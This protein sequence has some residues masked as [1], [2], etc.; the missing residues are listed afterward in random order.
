MEPPAS[1]PR[2]ILIIRPS[3]LGDVCRSV[4]VLAALRARWPDA[5]IDWLVQDAFAEA[6]AAHPALSE[7]VPFPRRELSPLARPDKLLAALKWG[8]SL[9]RRRYDLVIDC[10]GLM[11]SGVM[12]LATGARVRIGAQNARELSHAA[13]T[14]RVPARQDMHAVDR[15]LAL[16]QAAVDTFGAAE[17]IAAPDMRLYTTAE[18]RAKA[19][20]SLSAAGGAPVIV[21]A[22][23]SRWPAKQWPDERFAHLA[24]ALLDQSDATLVIVGGPGEQPQCERTRALS[25]DN[26]RVIDLVGQ[27][28]I[29]ELMAIVQRSALVVANDSAVLHM[30]VGFDRPLVALFG[31]TLTGLVGPYKRDADVL[32][33]ETP[34]HASAHKHAANASMMRAIA[35]EEAIEAALVRLKNPRLSRSSARSRA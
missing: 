7:V 32:Q 4:P 28:T 11:R 24:L 15:M 33:H 18:S 14:R 16:A 22:P 17:P 34:T 5:T 8:N 10:Q 27:T 3:A 25:S 9:R 26:P 31:P 21:L 6:I 23:T 29:G 20:R 1:E 19:E 13:Y 12:T 30:A 2:S 35:A